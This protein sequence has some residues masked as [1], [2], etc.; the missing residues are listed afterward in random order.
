MKHAVRYGALLMLVGLVAAPVWAAELRLTG[1]LDNIFPH[2]RSNMSQADGD[3]TRNED[4]TTM[5]RTR[6]RMYFN[7]LASDN[8][9]G[10]FGFELDC[11]WGRTDEGEADSCG[12]NTD[13]N[14]NIETKWLYV[15][16]RIPQVPIGNRSRLGAMPLYATPLH[17]Q[18]VLHGD[19]AGGDTVL[20]LSDQVALHL[21]YTQLAEDSFPDMDRFPGSAKVGE[22]FAT[23]GTLRLKPIEGLDLHLPL[24]YGYTESPFTNMTNN[25]S[26]FFNNVGHTTNIANE[27]R[28]YLG[29]DS[30]YRIGNLSIEPTFMYLLG[31]R[32]FTSASRARTGVGKT[33]FNAFVGNMIV[34]YSFGNLLLQGRYTYASGNNANDDINNTGIGNRA[35]VKNYHMMN[36]DGGPM[37]QEWFDIFGNG[38]VDGTSIDTF[39]RMGETGMLDIFGWQSVAIAPEYQ[40]RD[41]LTLEGAAG[42]FWAT[43]KTGCPAVF[44]QG[45]IGG[46]CTANDSPETY[47]GEPRLN[48]TGG[49]KFLGWEVAAGVRYT[50]MPGLTWTPRLSYADFGSGMDQN[51]RKAMDAWSFSNRIIYTF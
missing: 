27:S 24:V 29:F 36:A 51:G 15:D 21:Y 7:V 46:P 48:F 35:D 30:R 23:G 32:N 2:F 47:L 17:G 43:Q 20:T 31:T 28:Y 25:S 9:R 5:G 11:I 42:G 37:W 8:L 3:V 13:L 33:D 1:F 34:S 19:S 38:E 45:S 49:S 12:R 10:V 6:G 14:G 39:Q 26:P 18:L 41:D 4:Q 16:F 22:I 50:I 40:L 44:R